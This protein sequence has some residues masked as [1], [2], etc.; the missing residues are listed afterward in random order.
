M[1]FARTC[2]VPHPDPRRTCPSPSLCDLHPVWCL[3]WVPSLVKTRHCPV[4]ARK[5]FVVN[6]FLYF[7]VYFSIL[8]CSQQSTLSLAKRTL[9]PSLQNSRKQDAFIPLVPTLMNK[10]VHRSGVHSFLFRQGLQRCLTL[11]L[12]N[13]HNRVIINA[14]C[15]CM[16][17]VF[18]LHRCCC[19]SDSVTTIVTSIPATLSFK[20]L[21]S[22]LCFTTFV[23]F[24]VP[25]CWKLLTFFFLRCPETFLKTRW[26]SVSQSFVLP[27]CPCCLK[28]VLYLSENTT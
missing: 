6:T 24:L 18:L 14:L 8:A 9:L 1:P 4:S 21:C 25:R 5:T 12:A 11:Y 28:A 20:C 3:L 2:V 17:R 13:C 22:I 15:L 27:R 7:A 10:S 19:L 26:C 23:C 16:R